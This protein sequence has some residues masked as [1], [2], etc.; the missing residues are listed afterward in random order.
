MPFSMRFNDMTLK[1]KHS[2]CIH[3]TNLSVRVDIGAQA[4]I[5]SKAYVTTS[6]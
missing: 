3:L 4:Y 1:Y 2:L 5:L 6:M